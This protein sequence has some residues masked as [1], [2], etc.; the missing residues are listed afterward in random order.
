M[1]SFNSTGFSC[2]IN[3]IDNKACST[4]ICLISCSSHKYITKIQP[5][6]E[7]IFA[8]HLSLKK[9]ISRIYRLPKTEQLK[10]QTNSKMGKGLEFLHFS[11]KDIK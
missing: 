2:P 7:K 8:N 4:P 1:M 10:S 5:F 9:F 3:V 11:K 6:L